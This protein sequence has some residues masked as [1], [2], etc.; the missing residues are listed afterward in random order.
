MNALAQP[1]PAFPRPMKSFLFPLLLAAALPA[2]A[3]P[4]NEVFTFFP[5][6]TNIPDGTTAG[7]ADA[8]D[9]LSQ[10]TT[11][12]DV[13]VTLNLAGT[14]FGGFN[15]DLYATLVH[16]SGFSVLLN[17]P[18]RDLTRPFGYS[19]SGLSI[20][21]DDAAADDIHTYRLPLTG[22][23]GIPLAGLLTGDFQPDARPT[24]PFST[25]TGDARSSFLASFN[26]LN[27]NGEWVLF[28][29]DLELGGTLELVSWELELTGI[30]EAGTVAAGATLAGL[31][32]WTWWRRRKA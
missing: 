16:D 26:G 20:T 27:A 29:A 31:A 6:T 19:D 23:E 21:L 14:D 10:I 1:Q 15:G 9:I 13:N 7:L 4:F 30:P 12:T 25:L 2:A 17:R 22:D 24:D 5:S 18:G 32:G 8:R 28:I 3:A 11:I